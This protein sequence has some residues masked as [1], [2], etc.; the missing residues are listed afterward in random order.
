M[1]EDSIWEELHGH[2]SLIQIS[3]SGL[4]FMMPP[5]EI[6]VENH[7]AARSHAC[8]YTP[9]KEKNMEKKIPPNHYAEVALNY[10]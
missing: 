10:T 4:V 5:V 1:Y 8:H 6:I 9:V 7:Y 2:I 3:V